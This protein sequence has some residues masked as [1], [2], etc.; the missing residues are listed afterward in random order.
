MGLL[1]KAGSWVYPGQKPSKPERV[2]K[3]YYLLTS[4]FWAK[5]PGVVLV[6]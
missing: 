2:M 4:A 3:R 1:E 5:A 6:L